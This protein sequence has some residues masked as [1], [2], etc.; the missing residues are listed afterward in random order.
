MLSCCS[1]VNLNYKVEIQNHYFLE[2]KSVKKKKPALRWRVWLSLS[3]FVLGLVVQLVYKTVEG[4]TLGAIAAQ[5]AQNSDVAYAKS[6]F[7]IN[8]VTIPGAVWT[9]IFIILALTW[10]TYA[11]AF[12]RT[13]K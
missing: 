9:G 6:H 2:E 13:A 3:F 4:P 10:I 7:F 12:Y 1:K 5:Q 8:M 11:V